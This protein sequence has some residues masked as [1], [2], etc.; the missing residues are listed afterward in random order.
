[1]DNFVMNTDG[2]FGQYIVQE[3]TPRFTESNPFNDIYKQ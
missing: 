2:Q 1:M 3:L